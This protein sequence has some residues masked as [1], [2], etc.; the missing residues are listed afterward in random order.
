[1]TLRYSH[2]SGEHKKTAVKILDAPLIEETV[3]V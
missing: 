1:M 2:L 3:S